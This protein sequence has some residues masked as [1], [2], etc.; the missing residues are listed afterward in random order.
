MRL[1]WL[2]GGLLSGLVLVVACGG[3]DPP[4]GYGPALRASFVE[5]CTTDS[6]SAQAC[7]CFYDRLAAEVPFDRFEALDEK[8]TG[9]EDQE[10]PADLAGFAAGCAARSEPVDGG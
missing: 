3:D 8:L 6:A 2:R 1:S 10:L 9:D 7:G 4:D 5:E